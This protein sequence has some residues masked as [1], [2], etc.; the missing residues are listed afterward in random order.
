MEE[1]KPSV[2]V[3]AGFSE[4]ESRSRDS[5]ATEARLADLCKVSVTLEISEVVILV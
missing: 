1:E 3:S 4:S 2:A 5:D